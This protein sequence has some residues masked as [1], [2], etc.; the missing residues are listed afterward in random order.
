MNELTNFK[1]FYL[2]HYSHLCAYAFQ[3]LKSKDLSE[4]VVQ[5]VFVQLYE[6]H[7]TL[8]DIAHP[9]QYIFRAVK[10]KCLDVVRHH[11]LVHEKANKIEST[12]YGSKEYND[13]TLEMKELNA[14]I[15]QCFDAMPDQYSEPLYMS[16]FLSKKNREIAEVLDKTPK[17][18]ENAIYR[19]LVQLK[20][21]LKDLSCEVI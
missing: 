14:Q 21:C 6:K 10:F 4:D 18:I 5:E 13:S 11:Q 19:G 16:K 3:F 1:N 7:E 9:D 2:K 20:K 15:D 17:Q 8:T 12:Y